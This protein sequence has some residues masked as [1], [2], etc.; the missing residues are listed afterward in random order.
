MMKKTNSRQDRFLYPHQLDSKK[1]NRW[2]IL[3]SIPIHILSRYKRCKQYRI[4]LMSY[5]Y[6]KMTNQMF[7]LFILQLI[8]SGLILLRNFWMCWQRMRFYRWGMWK[9]WLFCN[10]RN[11]FRIRRY[12]RWL[13]INLGIDKMFVII[14]EYLFGKL[15]EEFI[16]GG[17]YLC[18]IM[19]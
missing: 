15:Y 12:W 19:S 13:E 2:T 1:W 14:D 7:I 11:L 6:R 17:L 3:T 8:R 5:F 18:S 9:G 4:Y 16:M 10:M